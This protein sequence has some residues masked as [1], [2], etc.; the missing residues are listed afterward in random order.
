MLQ[1][2]ALDRFE[3]QRQ[4][5]SGGTATVYRA[6]D[7]DTGALVAVKILHG[8]SSQQTG[9]FGQE[10]EVLAEL[11]HPAVVRYVA[12][13]STPLGEHYLAMEW[14]EGQNLSDRLAGGALTIAESVDLGRRVAGALASA[15]RRG[16]VHRDI[17]PSN[18]FLPG[19]HL[20]E[21]KLLDFGMARR[22]FDPRRITEAGGIMGTP[23][24]MAP[25]QAR[26]E[27]EIDARA[28]IF[29]LGCVM[30]ECLTGQPPFTGPTAM[31]VL[32]KICLDESL[33]IRELCP[34]LP[35]DLEAQLTRMLEKEPSARP[36]DA[37]SV[38]AEL[39]AISDRLARAARD[40]A[41][42][43]AATRPLRPV[44]DALTAGEQRVICVVL[45]TR[46]RP[47]PEANLSDPDE[48]QRPPEARRVEE[49]LVLPT[50]STFDKADFEGLRATLVPYGARV[51]RLLDGSMV[52][53]LSGRGAPT[54][55]AAHAARCALRLRA[56]LPEVAMTISTGRAVIFGQFPVGDVIDRGAELL[57]GERGG[58][59]RLD[60]VTADLLGT[61]FEIEGDPE[62][63]YLA[64]EHG[65]DDV[66]RTL[67][68]KATTCVGRDRELTLLDGTFDECIDEPVAR[69]VLVTAPAGG[70]KSRL[71]YEIVERLRGRHANLE[72]LIGRGDA[73]AA[74]S[75]FGL[76]A[77]ALREAAGVS[78]GDA[79][80]QRR[81]KLKALV[82]R[83][84]PA[85]A[86][87]WIWEFLGE[88]TGIPFDEG[89]SAGL[90]AARQD[91][92]LMGDRLRS[93]WLEWLAG[94]CAH[95]PVLLVLE[96]IHW[97]DRPSLQLVDAALR[98]L[99]E[100][101]FMVLAFAR[102]E[103]DEQFPNLWGERDLQRVT[104]RAL[105]RKACQNLAQQVL[106]EGLAP[107][108]QDW[109]VERAD[110]NPFY[111]EE[112]IRAVASGARSSLPETVVGMVQ[113]RL[114]TLGADAKRVLRAASVFGLSFRRG[115][116]SALISDRDRAALEG[117]L[118]ALVAREVILPE[119]LD[120]YVFRHALLREAAY[121]MLT[122]GDRGLG[123]LLAGEWL[124]QSERPDAQVL[125]EHFER[126]GD[127]LRAARWCRQAAEEAL[128]GNDFPGALAR[129]RRG[130]ALGATEAVRA[131]LR[132]CEAQAHFWRGEY[133]LAEE[134]A[135]DGIASARRGDAQWFG[136]V[137]E[138]VA[139]L[140]QQAK[141][142]EV[143][144]W[145]KTAEQTTA[146][147]GAGGVKL[148]CLIR[149][150]GYLLPGGLYQA[151]DA[152]LAQVEAASGGF[153]NLD[154][155]QGARVKAAQ[156]TRCLHSGDQAS[157][158]GLLEAAVELAA[159][160]GDVRAMC[161]MRVNL[162]SVWSDMGQ[163]EPAETLLRQTLQ[164][165][166]TIE[167]HYI[168]TAA[169]INLAPV[170]T[171]AGRLGEARRLTM[172]A[173]NFA[174]KQ[175]D[176]RWEGAAQLY[177]STISFM[178]GEYPGSEQRARQAAEIASAPL[179]PSAL[180]AIAR[181]LL[182]QDR[183]AEALEQARVAAAELAAVGHVE[184]Y[185]SLVHLMLAETL[186]ANGE[187]VAARAA[188]T[189]ATT[190]LRER[191]AQIGRLDW[192]RSFLTRLP[193]NARTLGLARAWGIAGMDDG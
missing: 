11:S 182:A 85:D 88:L 73:I 184:E 25:E 147:E 3:L 78:S 82:T 112:L 51:D 17:K 89:Q 161:E 153:T 151:T 144:G 176:V 178:A 71:R 41:S 190:R 116:V 6:L 36:R 79:P 136:C 19:N 174:R 28:D 64:N 21:A 76:L 9:R 185:E 126:G 86:Q 191:A 189:S 42:Q 172:Q 35:A 108:I 58:R 87:P 65:R 27:N 66:P 181:A 55:Q 5:G 146:R 100:K 188:L 46:P 166:Q 84:L 23:M 120:E 113:A 31:A 192:R 186:E 163:L 98:A 37:T 103:V 117:S 30:F 45:V 155:A 50:T 14:L 121:A 139:S 61:R 187:P 125:V 49:T 97:G 96:D 162:G 114:D 158:I 129:A 62:H 52:V 118:E 74:G 150:A 80:D 109:L 94:E 165:A 44:R 90:G 104:L 4:V 148:T 127:A 63:R 70:G 167:L 22:L 160:T 131:G 179:R 91:P 102:P 34:G 69:A 101:P 83:H 173:L 170:L 33:P 54:D 72:I 152:V 13:G 56:M 12:H 95:H 18:L 10:A 40:P 75:A 138:L 124:E 115:G 77:P 145:A 1:P 32:A 92:R 110:G 164:E 128:A 59:I 15:H 24:Y 135:R 134:A 106:G 47:R 48:R 7:R 29:S 38:E 119:G 154:P 8:R 57:S 2:G 132:L 149:S 133:A 142:A 26:G 169:L 193:D 168:A 130:V 159:A 122:E 107:A 93:A 157:A 141:Y 175:G 143:A 53:T 99:R 68:G 60:G 137:N 67:L 171:H 20:E 123:H 105:T 140:G 16:I 81:G 183:R 177:L 111:L 39:A 156:A 180:A 43:A